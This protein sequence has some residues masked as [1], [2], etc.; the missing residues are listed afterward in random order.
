MVQAMVRGGTN[1]AEASCFRSSALSR[2]EQ[3]MFLPPV[4]EKSVLRTCLDRAHVRILKKM[5][6]FMLLFVWVVF[7]PGLQPRAIALGKGYS[8]GL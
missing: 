4:L 6:L 7:C 1:I 3:Q 2:L 5:K 8:P